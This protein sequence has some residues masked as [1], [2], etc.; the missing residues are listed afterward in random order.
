MLTCRVK[1]TGL[2]VMAFA[3]FFAGCHGGRVKG[4]IGLAAQ[5][6]AQAM[7]TVALAMT[8]PTGPDPGIPE[9]E[10][11]DKV[12]E[13]GE[14]ANWPPLDEEL[15]DEFIEEL[16]DA[17]QKEIDRLR[18]AADPHD[19]IVGAHNKAAADLLEKVRDAL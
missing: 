17:L 5:R 19:P 18:A 16:K 3:I 13:A 8:S 1:L 4:G 15:R 14:N 6:A 2:I 7:T 9:E 11:I 10:L 12:K